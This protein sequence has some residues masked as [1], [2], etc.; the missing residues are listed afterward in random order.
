MAGYS[1]DRFPHWAKV[2]RECDTRET[3]LKRDGQ[4]VRVDGQ[5]RPISGRWVSPY[6]GGTWTKA[7]DVDIDHSV[8]LA[9]AWRS[10]AAQWTDQQ[11]KAFANDLVRHQ[12]F[13]VTDTVNQQKG[14]KSPDQWKPP[15]VSY[16]CTYA[17]NWIG[18]KH[19]YQLSVTDAEKTALSSMLDHC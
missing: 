4:D 14:D 2:D 7:S 18:V 16:W 12:L 17:G 15:L 10:G 13:A 11:R 1:R 19:F 5:C 3:V 6:D 8:P 9:A